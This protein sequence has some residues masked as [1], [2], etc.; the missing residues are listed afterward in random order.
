MKSL[1]SLEGYLLVDHRASP[2]LPEDMAIAAGYGP[3]G[4]KGI[5]ET[6]TVTCNHCKVV[7][8]LKSDRTRGRGFCRGCNHY[9]CDACTAQRALDGLCIPFDAIVEQVRELGEKQIPISPLLLPPTLR[10]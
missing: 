9:L 5:Y 6:A 10:K 3:D 7:V 8:V 4:G 1:K 2:G